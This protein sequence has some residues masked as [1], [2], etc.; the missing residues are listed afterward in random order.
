[1]EKSAR[2]SWKP[3]AKRARSSWDCLVCFNLLVSD[4]FLTSTRQ[5][6]RDGLGGTSESRDCLS[7]DIFGYEAPASHR[8]DDVPLAN[9]WISRLDTHAD[10]VVISGD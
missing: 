8:L 7:F 4:S 10:Y 9:G 6:Y 3:K 2:E 5:V 1:M